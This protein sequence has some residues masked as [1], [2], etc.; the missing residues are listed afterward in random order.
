MKNRMWL[1]LFALVLSLF[2][3]T[4]CATTRITAEW[5][6]ETFHE[7][8]HKVV[9][10]ASFRSEAVRNSFEDEFVR[11]LSSRGVEAIA[12]YTLPGLGDL[13]KKEKVIEEIQKIGAGAALV[14][15]LLDRR[16]A[17]TYVPGQVYVMPSYYYYWGP[18]FDYLYSPGYIVEEEYA[19]AETNIYETKDKRLVWSARSETLLSG[20]SRDLIKS[21]VETMADEIARGGLIR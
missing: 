10:V 3:L 6:D 5:K 4:S 16:T 20:R 13:K 18:Y 7:T 15:R 9:V 1:L 2:A 8:L 14:T 21:F 12:S 11:Q 17:R 19:H